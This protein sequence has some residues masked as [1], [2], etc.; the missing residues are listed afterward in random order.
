MNDLSRGELVQIVKDA[1]NKTIGYGLFTLA[2][3]IVLLAGAVIPTV[4]TITKIISEVEQKKVINEQLETKIL[5]LTALKKQYNSEVRDTL[6]DISL[7]YPN[8]GDFSLLVVNI[9]EISKRNGFTVDSIGFSE[10]SSS[11]SDTE[12][13]YSLL[14][15]WN[16]SLSVKGEKADIISLLSDLES[17]PTFSNIRGF[18]YNPT[19]LAEEGTSFNIIL[20]IYKVNDPNFY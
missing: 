3:I 10:P 8:R 13:A 7:V 15:P 1:K 11:S 2:A 5:A 14:I 12:V 20:E 9:D 17:M 16:V 4:A 18:T 19:E 6:E